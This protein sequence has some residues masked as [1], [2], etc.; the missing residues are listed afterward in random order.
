[1]KHTLKRLL[2][3]AMV[4]LMLFTLA[5]CG[6]EEEPTSRRKQE[7][8]QTTAD[9]STP[10]E[11]QDTTTA[12]TQDTEETEKTPEMETTLVGQWI[13]EVDV[14]AL[15]SEMFLA[16]DLGV[17]LE[18]EECVMVIN[19][20]FNED[21]T[22]VWEFD[23]DSMERMLDSFVDAVWNMTVQMMA[24]ELGGV[25]LSAAEE[26]LIAQGA[27][28][29]S[30]KKEMGSADMGEI[31]DL[32]GQWRLEGD[33]LYMFM[34]DSEEDVEPV[35]IEFGYGTFSI[36]EVSVEDEEDA[37][38]TEALLPIVFTRVK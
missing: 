16:L 17:E 36:V 20:T 7:N 13:G 22:S 26:V 5:A 21:G 6:E 19:A 31:E 15:V 4:L 14:S 10:E 2:C 37:E 34:E 27:T 8:V 32:K 29:E 11:T 35:T 38:M 28:K 12:E 23:E 3:L 1:M 25:S 24:E 9:T 33:Q 18:M 30:L